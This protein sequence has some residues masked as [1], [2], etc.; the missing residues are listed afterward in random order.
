MLFNSKQYQRDR[1]DKRSRELIVTNGQV[2]IKED[3]QVLALR[4][5][6]E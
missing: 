3:A 6:N 4:D 2:R 1:F 5:S